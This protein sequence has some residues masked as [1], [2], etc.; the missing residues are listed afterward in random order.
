M[1]PTLAA[2]RVTR[3]SWPKHR[4]T[5][6]TTAA[7]VQDVD[8]TLWPD[9]VGMAATSTSSMASCTVNTT[10]LDLAGGHWS[11]NVDAFLVATDFNFM[12]VGFAHVTLSGSL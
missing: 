12:T 3:R 8:P 1:L 11:G 7:S 2:R 10:Q 5:R 4:A 9:A 6:R